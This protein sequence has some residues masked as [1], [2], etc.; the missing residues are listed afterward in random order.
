MKEFFFQTHNKKGISF[1][2][3]IFMLEEYGFLE[4]QV[5]TYMKLSSMLVRL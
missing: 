2:L 5:S 1:N 3:L 4:L